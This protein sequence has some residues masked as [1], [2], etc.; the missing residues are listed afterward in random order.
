MS[1]AT[2]IYEG[3][4]SQMTETNASPAAAPVADE[5]PVAKI[6]TTQEIERLVPL[7]WPI[8]F[9]GK[10]YEHIR[11]RRITGHELQSYVEAMGAAGSKSPVPP[12]IECPQAVW[13]VMDA[14]DME[15]VGAN[16]MDFMPRRM[17]AAGEQTPSSGGTTSG[18]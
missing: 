17:K 11:V 9:E 3:K 12:T 8:E 15:N 4:Q 6:V 7:D 5:P 14:D 16:S 13:D 1:T 2:V 18:S 10:L